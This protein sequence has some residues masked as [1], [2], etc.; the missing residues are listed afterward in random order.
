MIVPLAVTLYWVVSQ[1]LPSKGAPRGYPWSI[2]PIYAGLGA[3]LM[4]YTAG[5]IFGGRLSSRDALTR[6]HGP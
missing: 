2:E 6:Q 4:V 5:W 1:A 3:S